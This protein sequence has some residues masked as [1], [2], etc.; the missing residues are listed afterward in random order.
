[1]ISFSVSDEIM[2]VIKQEFTIKISPISSKLN[3]NVIYF[4]LCISLF[5]A[6]YI[7]DVHCTV[8]V[9]FNLIDHINSKY[10]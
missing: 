3:E 5:W 1:M 4:F 7:I 9:F 8:K 10:L 2:V 6:M